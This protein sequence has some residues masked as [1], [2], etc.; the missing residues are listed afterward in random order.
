M[1]IFLYHQQNLFCFIGRIK[2]DD[3]YPAICVVTEVIKPYAVGFRFYD[4][5]KP[6]FQPD[7]LILAQAALKDGILYSLTLVHAFTG[8]PTETFL[9][10]TVGS[11]YIICNKNKH[12]YLQKN[13][14]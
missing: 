12:F 6:V 11:I 14:G 10:F 8:N 13:G 3:R 2:A 7:E 9:T 5:L 4:S 1:A